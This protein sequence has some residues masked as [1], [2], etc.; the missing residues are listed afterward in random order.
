MRTVQK[1][2]LVP[3]SAAMMFDLVDGCER[4][5]DFLPWCSAVELFERTAEVTR[6]RLDIDYHG[7]KTHIST[8]NRKHPLERMDI[9]FVAGPFEKF[10]GHWRFTALGDAGCRVDFALDYAFSNGAM[11]ALLAPVFGHIVDTLVEC[12]VRRADALAARGAERG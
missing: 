11:D 2:V 7:L 10:Q 5:P 4:Y 6:A 1:S 3:H 8:V 9:G 12:F